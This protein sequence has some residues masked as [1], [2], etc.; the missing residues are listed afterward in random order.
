LI[1]DQLRYTEARQPLPENCGGVRFEIIEK[2]SKSCKPM[3]NGPIVTTYSIIART[4]S[5]VRASHGH[6][7]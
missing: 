2:S 1:A 6:S 4:D 7:K 5:S 3:H